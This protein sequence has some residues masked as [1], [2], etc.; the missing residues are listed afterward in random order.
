[1]EA[2]DRDKEALVK[3]TLAAIRRLKGDLGRLQ[4]VAEAKPDRWDGRSYLPALMRFNAILDF[5]VREQQEAGA[6]T[7]SPRQP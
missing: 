7:R 6:P 2:H 1:M 5:I 3:A 4:E